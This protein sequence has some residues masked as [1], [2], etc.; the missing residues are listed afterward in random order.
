MTTSNGAHSTPNGIGHA[1]N[2][3]GS[4][5]Y[6]M[7]EETRK[8]LDV[9]LQL[10]KSQIPPECYQL[11]TSVSFETQNSGSPYF[12]APFKETEATGALK[13]VEGGMAAAI[14]DLVYGKK[15]RKMVVDLERASCFLF[16][17]YLATVAGM[18]KAHPNVR[19]VLKGDIST[20][21]LKSSY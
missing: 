11:I 21:S 9:L 19:S 5:R 12:P 10:A 4:S 18:N 7:L 2:G 1:I 6:S 16:S 15:E 17:A 20:W 3:S 8:S 13:A 14:A